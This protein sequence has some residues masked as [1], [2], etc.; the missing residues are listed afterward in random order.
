MSDTGT[1]MWV[2][3][4]LLLVGFILTYKN[5]NGERV[6]TNSRYEG[7]VISV[8]ALAGAVYIGGNAMKGGMSA[9]KGLYA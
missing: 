5:L 1:I 2:L 8:L 3:T 4:I 6:L 7:L 9:L